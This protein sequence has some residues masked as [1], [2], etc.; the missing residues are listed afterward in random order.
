M[1]VLALVTLSYQQTV[2]AYPSGG[3]SYIVAKENLS[4][5]AGLL[6]AAALLIDCVLTVA[7]SI[8][9]GAQQIT[10]FVP[11]L[12]PH[13]EA[14]CLAAIAFM[15]F[16]NLRGVKESGRLFA[17]PTYF[18]IASLLGM[19][20]VGVVGPWIGY[21]PMSLGQTTPPPQRALSVF[22]IL[23][24]FAGGCSALTGV[25][26]ISN[27]IQA[28]RPPESRNAAQTLAVMALLLGMMFVGVSHLAQA[29]QV[30]YAH[31]QDQESVLSL[32]ARAVFHD[33]GA[34]RATVLFSTA[35]ILV[36]AANTAYA[37]FPRLSAILA[38]DGFAPRPLA[39]FGDR[40]VYSNGIIV[41]GVFAALE[42][43]TQGAWVVLIVIP[44]L[45]WL[46]HQVQR[47]YTPL[48]QALTI[49]AVVPPAAPAHTVLV[50]VSRV[51][52][53]VME[54]LRYARTIAPDCR[55]V[56]IEIIPDDTAAL[57]ALWDQW[58]GGTPL[59][60]LESPYRSLIEPLLTYIQQVQQERPGQLVTVVLP[61]FVGSHWWEY[62]LHHNTAH[63]LNLIL[64]R[65][66]GVVVTEVRYSVQCG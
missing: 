4:V 59:V 65:L 13:P 66:K 9:A 35:L 5:A 34:L 52:R 21:H 57:R 42:K 22:V 24:A 62:L 37:D 25:E 17:V 60:I 10:S 32:I 20:G 7:V 41:L 40:L 16:A 53:G 43:T 36:L 11:A 50:P 55:A 49:E 28:F 38:R 61:Q 8:A 27:G 3:G 33:N 14:L 63:V 48:D 23:R 64:T 12:A 56:H 18:F 26:A 31:G 2:Y 15:T 54:A 29:S 6:A 58:G 46:F 1:V 39:R 19:I 51:N 45:T 30:V 47:Y 44:A